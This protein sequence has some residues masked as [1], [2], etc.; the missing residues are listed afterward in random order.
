MDMIYEKALLTIVA[1]SGHDANGGLPGV[2]E[3][4]RFMPRYPEEI[5][6]GVQLDVYLDLDQAMSRSVYSSRA[7][8]YVFILGVVLLA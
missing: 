6:P 2:E 1:A 8:T 3:G 5:I 4:S 7:W